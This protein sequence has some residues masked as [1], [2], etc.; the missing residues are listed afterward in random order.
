[1]NYRYLF[2][3]LFCSI[4]SI[5]IFCSERQSNQSLE[6]TYLASFF[7]DFTSGITHI[8]KAGKKTIN[9]PQSILGEHTDPKS[10]ETLEFVERI[11]INKI[12]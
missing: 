5:S 6:I 11:F 3:P 9:V 1:M 7:S 8:Y 4:V 10:K 12:K 2:I